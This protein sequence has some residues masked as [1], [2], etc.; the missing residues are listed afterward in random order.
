MPLIRSKVLL[1]DDAGAAKAPGLARPRAS[2]HKVVPELH[3]IRLG[4]SAEQKQQDVL[5]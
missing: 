4:Q 5:G 2:E 1:V 3:L